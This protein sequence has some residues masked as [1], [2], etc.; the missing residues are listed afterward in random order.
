MTRLLEPPAPPAERA[1][2]LPSEPIWPLSVAQYHAMIEAGILTEDDAIE[3]LEGLLVRKMSKN[4][5]HHV[6]TFLVRQALQSLIPVGW[7]VDSQEPITTPDSEPEPDVSMIRGA[8]TDSLARHPEPHEVGLVVEVADATLRRDRT[9]KKRIY[10]RAG[11]AIYWLV[12]LIDLQ[13]IVYTDPAPS[14]TPDYRHQR[15]YRRGDTIPVV[16]D[17]VEIGHI[18]VHDV[19]AE[20]PASPARP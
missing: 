2:V 12:N 15:T 18:A 19:L 5:P 1:D 3:L 6:V 4:P 20:L 10:A 8:I 9:T 7:Y 13:I 11:I 17:G 14:A 16:L